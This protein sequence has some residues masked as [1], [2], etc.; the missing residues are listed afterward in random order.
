MTFSESGISDLEMDTQTG[1]E[2]SRLEEINYLYYNSFKLYIFGRITKSKNV[3]L[4]N[5][6]GGIQL[7]KYSIRKH[8]VIIFARTTFFSFFKSVDV[9]CRTI[10]PCVIVI[11]VS[12]F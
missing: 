9:M 12:R 4:L 2:Q 1:L 6:Q 8:W 11:T 3:W 7:T 10:R 5:W